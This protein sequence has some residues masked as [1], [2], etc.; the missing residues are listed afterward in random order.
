MH[1]GPQIEA[2]VAVAS[3]QIGGCGQ[4]TSAVVAPATADVV[5]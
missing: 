1:G 2:C 4:M 3:G 5:A